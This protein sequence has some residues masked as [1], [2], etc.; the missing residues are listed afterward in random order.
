MTEL[1]DW[2]ARQRAAILLA[3]SVAVLVP[4]GVIVWM[5]TRANSLLDDIYADVH[6]FATS[7]AA[8]YT[9]NSAF[10]LDLSDRFRSYHGTSIRVTSA[11]DTSW[12][13]VATH[14]R[15]RGSCTITYAEPRGASD[16]QVMAARQTALEGFGCSP[17]RRNGQ[18]AKIERA[19]R[20]TS[21]VT[22]AVPTH[23]GA[24]LNPAD[25]T[26]RPVFGAGDYELILVRDARLVDDS[27]R[28]RGEVDP[29]YDWRALDAAATRA[30]TNAALSALIMAQDPK[31]GE[32]RYALTNARTARDSSTALAEFFRRAHCIAW[33]VGGDLRL[34]RSGIATATYRRRQYCRGE[35]PAFTTQTWRAVDTLGACVELGRALASTVPH[36]TCDYGTDARRWSSYRHVGDTIVVGRS[37]DG[38]DTF[39]LRVPDVRRVA[40]AT[41]AARFVD[42]RSC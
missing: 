33:L 18:A 15:L 38:R 10:A 9:D 40:S 21:D 16:K 22:R 12:S 32:D 26:A 3:V 36:V 14:R 20:D 35:N 13:A 8:Y 5:A 17:L 30:D 29:V 41:T 19:P 11:T 37:C 24:S 34:E 42:D 25:S 31:W 7:Q 39:V 1:V 6:N 27:A 23:A 4:V 2:R 28:A